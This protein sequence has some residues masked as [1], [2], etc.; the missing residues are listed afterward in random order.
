MGRTFEHLPH[1][2]LKHGEEGLRD[3]VLAGLNSHYQGAATGETFRKRGKT[4]I[5]IEAESRDAFV[6]ECKIWRGPKDLDS[7]IDQLLG[8]LTWRDCRTAFVIFNQDNAKFTALLEAVGRGFRTHGK[9]RAE[10]LRNEDGEWEFVMASMDD[11]DRKLI[12]RV[13]CF[14]LYTREK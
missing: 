1:T 10:K 3:I 8:Y 4:D 14:N 6:A 12:V 2:F 9:F 11:D 7:G 13:L 5:H